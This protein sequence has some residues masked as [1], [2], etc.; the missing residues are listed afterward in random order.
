ELLE[1]Q[2]GNLLVRVDHL[3]VGHAADVYAPPREGH[4]AA[5]SVPHHLHP[6]PAAGRAGDQVGGLVEVQPCE[7][8]PVD[9]GDDITPL[10]LRLGGRTAVDHTDDQ[11]TVVMSLQLD[12]DADDVLAEVGH[13]HA[14]V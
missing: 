9:P 8:L 6:Q 13:L 2:V 4:A 11:C 10:Q 1:P 14:F 12:A 7:R 3:H 5:A